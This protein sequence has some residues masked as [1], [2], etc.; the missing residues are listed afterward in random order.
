M[1]AVDIIPLS[2]RISGNFNLA[3]RDSLSWSDFSRHLPSLSHQGWLEK[4]FL[5]LV[6]FAPHLG[7]SRLPVK[8]KLD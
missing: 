1:Q 8:S 2:V 5:P 3:S 7:V 4:P 6:L